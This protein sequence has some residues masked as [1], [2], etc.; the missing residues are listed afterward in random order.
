MSQAKSYSISDILKRS[1]GRLVNITESQGVFESCK[2]TQISVLE[3]AGSTDLAFFFSKEYQSDLLKTNAG[4]LITGEAFVIPLENAKLPFWKSTIVIACKDP[5]LAM[6]KLSKLFSDEE[7]AESTSIH[8]SAIIDPSAK[9]GKKVKIGPYCVVDKNCEIGDGTVLFSHVTLYPHTKIGSNCR[10]HAQV[11]IGSDG[12]G[13]AP[14]VS[15]GQVHDHEKIWHLGNVIVGNDVEI[16][17]GTQIDRAT[18][19]STIIEDKV[20]IDNHCHL[21]HNTKVGKGTIIC[22]AVGLAGGAEV[23][24]F[25]YIG[26]MCGLS[27]RVKIGDRA[28]ITGMTGIDRDVAPGSVVAGIPFRAHKDNYRL[29]VLFNRMLEER[30]Q[31]K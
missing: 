29:Q 26:G 12:F 11:V 4:V 7:I 19:G 3:K 14:V 6:A 5:Y 18:F 31:K 23:G 28:K 25:V 22:G 2:I 21:G 8:R 16:G 9:I 15:D 17:A 20:K 30:K 1:E 13:Y 27:N 24:E 10:I